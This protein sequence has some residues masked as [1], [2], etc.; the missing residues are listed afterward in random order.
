M[1]DFAGVSTSA[2]WTLASAAHLFQKC[3]EWRLN[4]HKQCTITIHG[5]GRSQIHTRVLL[6]DY[7]ITQRVC[8]KRAVRLQTAYGG[9]VVEDAAPHYCRHHHS[10]S[11]PLCCLLPVSLTAVSRAPASGRTQ[12][13][14]VHGTA[15]ANVYMAKLLIRFRRRFDPSGRHAPRCAH[16]YRFVRQ[17][18]W[19]VIAMVAFP[20]K[21]IK[22]I[23]LKVRNAVV[24]AA[25]ET[26][27]C[28][29]VFLLLITHTKV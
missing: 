9:R 19:K 16:L 13:N 6:L 10:A 22:L 29:L 15:K 14:C 8:C 1:F 2:D 26:Y 4:A 18:S 23:Q 27:F 5:V 17:N 11:V 12:I 24:V 28:F 7:C 25:S 3:F 21:V 20:P